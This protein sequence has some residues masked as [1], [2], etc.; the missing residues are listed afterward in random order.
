MK[1]YLSFIIFSFNISNG[2]KT[3][4]KS[5]TV[6]KFQQQ[7]TNNETRKKKETPNIIRKINLCKLKNKQQNNRKSS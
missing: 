2:N 6:E 3:K 4:E 5:T 1:N 7:K